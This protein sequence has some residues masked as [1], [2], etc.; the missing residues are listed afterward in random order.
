MPNSPPT[1]STISATI[2]TDDELARCPARAGASGSTCLTDLSII[3]RRGFGQASR[4]SRPAFPHLVEDVI[5]ADARH[6]PRAA[7]QRRAVVA[8]AISPRA[9]YATLLGNAMDKGHRPHRRQ[10]SAR[11]R[12]A[13]VSYG[14]GMSHE[15]AERVFDRFWR[16]DPSRERDRRDRPRAFDARSATRNSTARAR[17]NSAAARGFV[18]APVPHRRF[19]GYWPIP[20]NPGDKKRRARWGSSA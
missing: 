12:S 19:G 8:P 15:D 5:E 4:W 6:S 1:C 17:P 11:R 7:A 18:L 14:M 16:A 9:S 20:V 10:R 2:S 13:S 3:D